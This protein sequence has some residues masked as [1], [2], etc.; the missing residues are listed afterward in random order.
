[1]FFV[2]C[3]RCKLYLYLTHA[4]L[5]VKLSSINYFIHVVKLFYTNSDLT[6]NEYMEVPI[7]LLLA[8]NISTLIKLIIILHFLQKDIYNLYKIYIAL[9]CDA[10][11]NAKIFELRVRSHLLVKC[12]AASFICNMVVIIYFSFNINILLWE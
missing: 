2:K 10:S 4:F 6:F 5:K 1:M 7:K 12:I 11:M 9:K 3:A 8:C